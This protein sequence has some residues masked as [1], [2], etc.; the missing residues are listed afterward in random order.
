MTRRESSDTHRKGDLAALLL[1]FACCGLPLLLIVGAS[2]A[3]VLIRTATADIAAAGIL[4]LGAAIYT[5]NKR[6]SKR[7]SEQP[8]CN[9]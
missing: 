6:R 7:Q 2:L 3:S 4:V 1:V 8:C 9:K 5:A